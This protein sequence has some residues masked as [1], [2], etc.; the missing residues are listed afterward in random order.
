[1]LVPADAILVLERGKVYDI[2]CHEE[3]LY[4]C[5]IYKHLWNQQNRHLEQD[6]VNVRIAFPRAA[7][8]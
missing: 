4:R 2:G 5:D 3:L 1:M 7:A 6:A 8:S